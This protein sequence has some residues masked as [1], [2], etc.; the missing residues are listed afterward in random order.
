M[1]FYKRVLKEFLLVVS[2]G[3]LAVGVT[4]VLE[5]V[6]GV[7]NPIVFMQSDVK[8]C[9]IKAGDALFLHHRNAAINVGDVVLSN[10]LGPERPTFHRVIGVYDNPTSA[11]AWFLTQGGAHVAWPS[12]TTNNQLWLQQH[13]IIGRVF[14]SLP[15]VGRFLRFGA[16]LKGDTLFYLAAISATVSVFLMYLET[17]LEA[18]VLISNTDMNSPAQQPRD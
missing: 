18:R 1:I 15:Y 13:H 10:V 5:F 4:F 16:Y 11:S 17:K 7:Q 3:I 6:T 9:N 2:L 14:W 8:E 12:Y